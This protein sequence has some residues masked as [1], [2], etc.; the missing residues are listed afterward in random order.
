VIPASQQSK[1]FD[2]TPPEFSVLTFGH[3]S[4]IFILPFPEID[5]QFDN[6]LT[7]ALWNELMS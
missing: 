4:Q 6:S 3:S 1:L 7:T 5:M 2:L